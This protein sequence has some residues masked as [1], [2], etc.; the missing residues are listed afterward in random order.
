MSEY[1]AVVVGSGPN[2]LVG[3][4]LLA[5]SGRRVLV[6]EAE[7][8]VGGGTRTEELTLPGFR[9]D[10]CSSVHPLAVSSPA[11]R[12]LGLE[13]EGLSWAHPPIPLAHPL[14]DEPAV[15]LERSVDATAAGLGRGG[16]SWKLLAGGVARGGTPL[17]DSLLAPLS[18]P[19]APLALAAYGTAG[20][21]P[22][23][24][25]G[26]ALPGVRAK[27]LLGGLSAHSMLDL[28]APITGGFGLLLGGMAHSVGW[29]VAVGGSQAIADAL[30]ARLT[31][32]GGEVRTGSRVTGAADLPP[33]PITLLD[34]SPASV[35]TLL[36]DR[37]PDRYVRR[38]QRFRSGPGVFKLDWALDGPVPWRDPEVGRAATVHLGGTLPEVV[39]AERT[40][41]RGG[42]PDRP[43]VLFVQACVA[44]PSRAPAGQHTAWAYCHVPN[45][46]TVDMTAAI[47]AQVERF[48][49]GFRD[50]V[51]A[52]H[53][54]GPA[55]YQA[56]NANLTG[57]DIGG[58]MADLR[59]FL[60]RPVLSRHPWALPV[61][62]VY[63]CSA[64]TPPGP[65]VHGMGGWH[66]A[67]LALARD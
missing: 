36:G 51:L 1:D 13:A 61:P 67:R 6:L 19:R 40:V 2:G 52:R 64:S 38:L 35:V 49:P 9:H 37:M 62:G 60:A 14:D 24:L 46:S 63:L 27:A 21:W 28:H 47:E 20:I 58:G 59:Q 31:R 65:G 16:R 42:H 23:T 5:E 43:F 32:L 8:R 66:A 11:F 18:L 10:V 45:G 41:A 54:M 3:A 57:G 17:A 53:A 7:D 22:A 25:L 55:D 44:D 29:P 33:A 48:A 30:V 4:V 26:R 39:A 12:S 50:R 15:L 56:H 34:L